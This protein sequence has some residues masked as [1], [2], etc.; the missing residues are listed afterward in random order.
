[1]SVETEAV[2]R[3]RQLVAVGA[4]HPGRRR[5]GRID[6]SRRPVRTS[7]RAVRED[8][9]CACQ[10][11]DGHGSDRFGMSSCERGVDLRITLPVVTDEHPRRVRVV[12]PQPLQCYPLVFCAAA[13]PTGVGR[14]PVSEQQ[15]TGR[16]AVFGHEPLEVPS[17]VPGTGREVDHQSV[18]AGQAPQ[19]LAHTF[20]RS[21]GV[22]AE[23]EAVP[24]REQGARQP[25][26]EDGVV[27]VADD[28][29][30]RAAVDHAHPRRHG[31][32]SV[33]R[34]D[35]VVPS[36]WKLRLDLC[37]HVT[38]AV[39]RQHVRAT[40]DLDLHLDSDRRDGE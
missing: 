12:P 19:Q 28:A 22:L 30:H 4:R 24:R 26:H 36:G 38:A 11:A 7:A 9:L 32:A 8:V 40:A 17:E 31:I 34:D 6:R 16:E 21:T 1:M 29:M 2:K 3:R 18:L 5:D 27:D 23:E 13:E 10:L 14:S 25:R 37:V 33:D 20:N 15:R 39:R 35:R